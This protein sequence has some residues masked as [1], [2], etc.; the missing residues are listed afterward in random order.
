[1]LVIRSTVTEKKQ[2][3]RSRIHP[4]QSFP[5]VSSGQS[6]LPLPLFVISAA[7]DG[8][9]YVIRVAGELDLSGCPRLD[10]ALREAEV[11]HAVRILLDL[12][13]LTFIDAAGLSV[14]VAAWHR[15]IT[16]SN[17]LQVTPGRGNVASMFRLTALDLVL[18]FSPPG[19]ARAQ[20]KEQNP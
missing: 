6:V 18:P 7:E 20:S 12:D 19:P 10:H 15:S 9:T 4:G 16:D 11:S 8:H 13:E 17:R 2:K 14:L 5:A 3:E 1:V